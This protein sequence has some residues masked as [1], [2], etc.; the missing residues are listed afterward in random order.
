VSGVTSGAV[1]TG[2]SSGTS[3]DVQVQATNASTTSP[4][5][6]S[7]TTTASTYSTAMAWYGTPAGSYTHGSGGHVVSVSTTPNPSGSVGVNFW[8]STSAT[9]NTQSAAENTS[10]ASGGTDNGYPVFT[11][12]WGE[13]ATAPT[14]TGTYYIWAIIGDGSG[15]L[16]SSAITVS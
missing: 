13:Y 16:V 11:N 5:A 14:A 9:T 2:L 3:Y 8:W 4:G 1:I 12:V 15:A 7:S 6:W 10:R